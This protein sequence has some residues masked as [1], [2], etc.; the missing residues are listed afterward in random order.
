MPVQLLG[1][2]EHIT[3]RLFSRS[4]VSVCDPMDCSAPG[5]PVLHYLPEFAQTHVHWVILDDGWCHPAILSSVI[6]F[7]S[8]LQSFLS[9]QSFLMSQLFASGGQS[10]EVSASTSV[11][12]MNIQS[13]FP[14][15]LTGLISLLSEGLSRAFSSTTVQSISSLELSLLFGPTLTSIHHYWKNQS[16][17]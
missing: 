4:V 16:F 15:G 5:F 11:L 14:V 1:S 17:D 8:C 2:D 9:S 7:S 3:W 13:W 12:P 10:I 6:P